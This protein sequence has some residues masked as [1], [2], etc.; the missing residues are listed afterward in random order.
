MDPLAQK[1]RAIADLVIDYHAAAFPDVEFS[2]GET[3]V[4]YAGRVFDSEELVNGV[5]AV[6]DFWLTAGRFSESLETDLAELL[7]LDTVLLVNSGSSANL[8]AFSALTSP[9]LGD[10]RVC[11]GD[12]VITVAAGFPTTV[13]PIIQNGAVPVF[14]DVELGSYAPTPET[15]AAAVTPRTKAVM[16]AHTLGIPFDVAAIRNIC[17]EHNLWLIEDCCDALG[18]KVDDKYLGT[19]G[20]IATLSFYPAHQ[21]TMGEGGAVLTN[22]PQLARIA[23]SFRDWGRDCYCSGGESNTCGMR[24]SQ[25][26]GT[27]PKGYDHKYVY[28]HIGYNLKVTDIQAAIGCA[29]LKKLPRFIEARRENW[30]ALRKALD[31]FSTQLI[32]PI[33]PDRSDPCYFG[34]VITV[35]ENAPFTRNQLTAYLEDAKI[36]TR[37]LFCGNITRQPAYTDTNFRVHGTLENTDRIMNDTFFIGVYP[38]MGSPQIKYVVEV[39]ERF[40]GDFGD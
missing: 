30:F 38:G 12:E 7:D 39:F 35:D 27:L 28:S 3:P 40:M 15:I 16:I 14:V 37:N 8:V 17:E 13:N 6:L 20:D 18:G 33:T 32:L 1:R 9:S 22:N 26:F 36:E 4:R 24:F 34:F 11:P 31:R 23:T 5:D 21:I 25:Q 29:Q 19:F 2:P 10:R